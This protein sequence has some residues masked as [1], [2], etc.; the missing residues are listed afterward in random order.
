MFILIS[1]EASPQLNKALTTLLKRNSYTIDSAFDGEEAL[2]F[3]RDY[4]YDLIIL[5]IML[6]K[7]D[8]LEV[9]RS[10]RRNKITTPVIL[11]TAKSS[12]EDKILG[13]DLGA[14]D[15]LPKPFSTEELLARVRALARRNKQYED[16]NEITFGD[17][18]INS[19]TSTCKCKEKSVSLSSKE[20]QILILLVKAKGNIVSAEQIAEKAWDEE[21]FSTSENVWVFISM[22]RKKLESLDAKTVIK[23]KRYQGYYLEIK[24]A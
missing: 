12:V 1:S 15:Y 7:V 16:N 4:K 17:L 2:L 10:I 19:N 23:S 14:D 18:V 20:L 6:P 24:N 22:I 5:D 13:L 3:V 21:S 9:L 8:G 11:L